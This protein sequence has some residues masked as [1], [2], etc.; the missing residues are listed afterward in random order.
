MERMKSSSTNDGKTTKIILVV[1]GILTIIFTIACL[2]LFF[3][4]QSV[5]D[6]LVSAWFAATMGELGVCGWIKT[7]K[8]K[9]NNESEDNEL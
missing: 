8:T 9:N 3:L 6:V 5:P 1:V 4:F 7:V 2:W